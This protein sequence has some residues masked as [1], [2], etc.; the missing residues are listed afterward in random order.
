MS[1]PLWFVVARD[2]VEAGAAAADQRAAATAATGPRSGRGR[3]ADASTFSARTV[4]RQ[5]GRG[6]RAA[7]RPGMRARTA[8]PCRPTR[9]RRVT[10]PIRSV[11]GPDTGC[12]AAARTCRTRRP[13]G[14]PRQASAVTSSF[15][16]PSRARV[17]HVER[18]RPAGPPGP[19]SPGSRRT[20]GRRRPRSPACR[21]SASWRDHR[22]QV[23]QRRRARAA[24]EPDPRSPRRA[25][26]PDAVGQVR[27]APARR[28]R[29]PARSWTVPVE[30]QEVVLQQLGDLPG[31]VPQ[32]DRVA[33]LARLDA[34]RPRTRSAPPRSAAAPRCRLL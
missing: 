31:E 11:T 20:S 12:G 33:A 6:A 5:P 34:G 14:P 30:P 28:R 7:R 8:V 9:R 22:E 29:R 27:A 4:A 16:R 13:S 19:G 23:V 25:G 2:H 10:S 3:G 18:T 32:Q 26:R 1:W 17:G 24:R 21:C 15:A